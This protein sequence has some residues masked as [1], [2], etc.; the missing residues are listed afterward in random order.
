[1]QFTKDFLLQLAKW[2]NINSFNKLK[3]EHEL[4]F[5][6]VFATNAK[7]PKNKEVWRGVMSD[8]IWLISILSSGIYVYIKYKKDI[9]KLNKRWYNYKCVKGGFYVKKLH[10]E[11]GK[12]N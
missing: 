10:K 8:N 11:N 1:M 12:D 4:V 9:E 3:R 7:L 6:F 2:T 5:S